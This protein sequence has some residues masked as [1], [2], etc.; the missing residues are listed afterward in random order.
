[1]QGSINEVTCLVDKH[2]K[3]VSSA[4]VAQKKAAMVEEAKKRKS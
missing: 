1:M 3:K 2:D 4:E